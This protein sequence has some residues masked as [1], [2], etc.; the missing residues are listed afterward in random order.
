MWLCRKIPDFGRLLRQNW[1]V[2]KLGYPLE[3]VGMGMV[4]HDT[5]P[6]LL[7]ADGDIAQFNTTGSWRLPLAEIVDTAG[8]RLCAV[9]CTNELVGRK[10]ASHPFA[11]VEIL[12]DND[13]AEPA[14]G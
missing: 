9:G 12:G 4:C 7:S 3:N 6:L 1:V 8:R 14:D 5:L 13:I 11:D 2:H 10:R